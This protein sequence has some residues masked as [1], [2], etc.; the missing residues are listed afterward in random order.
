MECP[1]CGRNISCTSLSLLASCICILSHK[2]RVSPADIADV[3]FSLGLSESIDVVLLSDNVLAV[4]LSFLAGCSNS[5]V[6]PHF[7]VIFS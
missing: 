6:I 2:D 4:V 3:I 5:L 7:G 1:D